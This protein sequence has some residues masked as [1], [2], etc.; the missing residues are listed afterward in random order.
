MFPGWLNHFVNPFKGTGERI[1]IAFNLDVEID[2][3]RG[4]NHVRS[5]A[6][7]PLPQTVT[8]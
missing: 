4:K 6:N 3:H 2:P 7:I 1:S 8:A 5:R